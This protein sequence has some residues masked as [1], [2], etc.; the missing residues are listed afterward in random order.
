MVEEMKAQQERAPKQAGT[1]NDK[2]LNVFIERYI[3][4]LNYRKI[5]QTELEKNRDDK[6]TSGD[7]KPKQK[8]Y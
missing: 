4:N 1:K 7:N 2:S 8:N 6:K 3:D 5:Y